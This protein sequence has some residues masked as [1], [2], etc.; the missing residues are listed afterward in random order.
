VFRYEII[1]P[2]TTLLYGFPQVNQSPLKSAQDSHGLK[3][4]QA[5]I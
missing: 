4:L 3:F 1:M 5:L 2:A